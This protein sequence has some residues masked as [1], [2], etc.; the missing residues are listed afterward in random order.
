MVRAKASCSTDAC[1]WCKRK[2]SS[3]NPIISE[4]DQGKLT[5]QPRKERSL[6]CRTCH[7]IPP[8]Y[9]PGQ[10]KDA[11]LQSLEEEGKRDE[12]MFK[13]AHHEAVLNGEASKYRR[14]VRSDG[15]SQTASMSE[16][17]NFEAKINLGV[18]WT[19]ANWREDQDLSGT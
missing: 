6:E 4:R 1:K 2:W 17:S 16:S 12:F 7:Q 13:V 10:G 3:P 8:K 19:E 5:L 18:L 14:V 15:V 11:L 9:Y